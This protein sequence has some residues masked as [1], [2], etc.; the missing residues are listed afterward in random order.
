MSHISVEHL[1]T[2]SVTSSCVQVWSVVLMKTPGC[3]VV[4]LATWDNQDVL[5]QCFPEVSGRS[6]ISNQS[7]K[8]LSKM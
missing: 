2:P 6:K 4:H 7:L 8:C 5:F 3:D 1:N